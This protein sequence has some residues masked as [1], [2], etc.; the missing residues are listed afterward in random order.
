MSKQ[1]KRS[2]QGKT[3]L[4]KVYSWS[5]I[6]HIYVSMTLLSLLALFCVTGIFLNHTQWFKN[7]YSDGMVELKISQTLKDRLDNQETNGLYENPPL[8]ELQ[9]LL[10]ERYNLKHIEDIS[11]DEDANEI[12]ID[13]QLPSGYA[14]AILDTST[15]VL[16]LEYRKGSWI[17][18]MNDLHKGR[19]TGTA[20]S[21]VID[22]SAGLMLIFAITGLFIL[23]QN[24]KYRRAGLLCGIAG[25]I[26]PALIY[27]FWVPRLAGV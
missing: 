26:T 18:I 12:M 4:R 13:F 17:T 23:I 15:Q 25:T 27:W 3:A 21:W 5:R 1:V 2:K 22:L 7:S 20:W 24:K 16:I 11:L 19:H 8:A 9:A 14:T 6:F 10:N